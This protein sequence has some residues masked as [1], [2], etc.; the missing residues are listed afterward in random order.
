MFN[1]NDIV[2]FFNNYSEIAIIL[3]LSISI[4]IAIL[5]IIPSVF[6]TGANIL[7]FGPIF[8]FFISIMGEVIG[9]W[10][11]FRLYRK[12]FKKG[13]D[14]LTNKHKLLEN[15][16]KSSGNKCAFLILQG[17]IIPFIP[18]G[19]VTLAA[20]ISEIDDFRYTIAT[21]IGKIP[22]I[23]IEVLVSYGVLMQGQKF[24]QIALAILGCYFIYK[25]IRKM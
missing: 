25:T 17:R 2:N 4:I 23:L 7:F 8:G 11:T 24:I 12:G 19:V 22:S 10:I 15:I 16:A 13:F 20:A 6:V 18:S 14:S 3:S 1:V 5:G 21:F 9:G